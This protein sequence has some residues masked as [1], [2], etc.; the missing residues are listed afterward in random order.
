[1]NQ[2]PE[3]PEH[4]ETPSWYERQPL[5]VKAIITAV[6]ILLMFGLMRACVHVGSTLGQRL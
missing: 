2:P 1:M 3:I 6:V 4:D 5:W